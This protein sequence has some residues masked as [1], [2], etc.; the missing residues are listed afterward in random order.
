MGFGTEFGKTQVEEWV[1]WYFGYAKVKA[2]LRVKWNH[3]CATKDHELLKKLEASMK[4]DPSQPFAF[5]I[6][7]LRCRKVKKSSTPFAGPTSDDSDALGHYEVLR[8]TCELRVKTVTEAA[9]PSEAGGG[10]GG[11][12][13]GDAEQNISFAG[14]EE[15]LREMAFPTHTSD[16]VFGGASVKSTKSAG[17]NGSPLTATAAQRVPFGSTTQHPLAMSIE[18]AS[19]VQSFCAAPLGGGGSSAVSSPLGAQLASIADDP[20]RPQIISAI[21]LDEIAHVNGRSPMIGERPNDD[22]PLQ[23]QASTGSI[24]MQPVPSSP[25]PV[26]FPAAADSRVRKTFMSPKTA[27][28]V[29]DELEALRAVAASTITNVSLYQNPKQRDTVTASMLHPG[30][31]FAVHK[32]QKVLSAFCSTLDREMTK[33]SNFATKQETMLALAAGNAIEALKQWSY[34]SLDERAQL[35]VTMRQIYYS[36]DLLQQYCDDNYQAVGFILREF[37]A[38]TGMNAQQVYVPVMDMLLPFAINSTES[39]L[40]LIKEQLRRHYAKWACEGDESKASDLLRPEGEAERVRK[41]LPVIFTLGG[42]LGMIV[43]F[44]TLIAVELSNLQVPMNVVAATE[45]GWFFTVTLSVVLCMII[46]SL[47]VMLWEKFSINYAF[48]LCLDPV[49]HWTGVELLRDQLSYL[50]I[51]CACCYAF[52]RTGFQEAACDERRASANS[53]IPAWVWGYTV[54]F[55]LVGWMIGRAVF[56]SCRPIGVGRDLWFLRTMKR[57]VLTPRYPILFS[58][59]FICSQLLALAAMELELQFIWCYFQIDGLDPMGKTCRAASRMRLIIIPSI[60]NV[61]RLIQCIVKYREQPAGRRKLFPQFFQIVRFAIDLFIVLV[62]GFFGFSRQFNANES[63]MIAATFFFYFVRLANSLYKIV[64]DFLVASSL[65]EIDRPDVKGFNFLGLNLTVRQE[66]IY[67]KWFYVLFIVMN[68]LLRFNWL[69]RFFF[70]ERVSRDVW[71]WFAFCCLDLLR[72]F[73]W[74]AVRVESDQISNVE[75]FK[76]T[77]LAPL[78]TRRPQLSRAIGGA[79]TTK[80]LTSDTTEASLAQSLTL[81]RAPERAVGPAYAS[82]ADLDEAFALL[83]THEAM[84]AFF[85]VSSRAAKLG[86]IVAEYNAKKLRISDGTI[87]NEQIKKYLIDEFRILPP[88]RKVLGWIVYAGDRSLHDT[89]AVLGRG[90]TF[91]S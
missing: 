46:F 70:R 18:Q 74:N 82:V 12:G 90:S 37:D 49:C 10:G 20:D 9:P 63:T 84:M 85:K 80:V 36:L 26:A 76:A 54:P 24:E 65:L 29:R 32:L 4:L 55:L 1:P 67:P 81:D 44:V 66:L 56:D 77:R 91:A 40:Q 16:I 11:G 78:P 89:F 45:A 21:N 22:S 42:L 64:M 88:G 60:P 34:M 83:P 68:S 27:A 69:A 50:A 58:D 59:Y 86:T 17:G 28:N 39:R 23:R 61:W 31:G 41:D 5:H 25:Q 72:R 43:I 6:S 19:L 30:L 73:L 71:V 48:I 7:D 52:L 35:L 38:Q 8:E 13:G 62:Q 33:V 87:T 51:W 57:I 75:S 3:F 15:V 2:V 14:F 53:V 47:N 79:A